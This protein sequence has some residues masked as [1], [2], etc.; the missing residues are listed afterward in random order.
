MTGVGGLAKAGLRN[1]KVAGVRFVGAIFL[2]A[3]ASSCT[4]WKEHALFFSQITAH[5][6]SAI[7]SSKAR[8][9][10]EDG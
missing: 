5:T 1:L 2:R 7:A 6:K 8:L 10:V 3:H 4:S 9:P